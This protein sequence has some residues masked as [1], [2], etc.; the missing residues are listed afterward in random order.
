MIGRRTFLSSLVASALAPTGIAAF[1]QTPVAS[2]V[3]DIAAEIDALLGDRS[4]DIPFTGA[5]LMTNEGQPILNSAYGFADGTA[6]TVN[7]S[8]TGFQIASITKT[9]TA[10]LTMQLRNEGAFELDDPASALIPSYAHQL[11]AGATPVT[12]RQLLNHTSG[13]PDF[14]DIL[15]P[16]D[17]ENYPESLDLLLEAIAQVPLM[18]DPGEEYHYSNSGYLYLGRIIEAVTGRTWEAALNERIVDPLHLRRTWLTPPDNRG[19]LATGYLSIQG[20]VL[21]V[22]RFGRP[23]LAEA[24]GGLTSTTADL[25][26]WLDAFMA[27][28]IVPAET[29]REML[30]PGESGY[31][32]GWEEVDVDGV[33]WQGHFG[34]TIGFRTAMF[35]QQDRNQSIILLSNRQDYEIEATLNN[36]Q[37]LIGQL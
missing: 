35:R 8:D 16:F 14:L 28:E 32:L 27:G 21:P 26:I 25:L 31:G 6:R 22:S 1:A 18:F 36:I 24:A 37:R 20:F 10:A 12:I 17:L 13:V 30:E 29:V 4:V 11:D 33:R 15:D 34:Q 9:F 19:D 2:P 23:D 7:T 3:H 5:V